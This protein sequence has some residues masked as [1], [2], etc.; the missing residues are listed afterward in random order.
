MQLTALFYTIF[1]SESMWR[2][3]ME[4]ALGHRAHDEHDFDHYDYYSFLIYSIHLSLKSGYLQN[5]NEFL[6]E[7]RANRRYFC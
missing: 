2:L 1:G 6:L 4:P 7:F 3:A 5:V